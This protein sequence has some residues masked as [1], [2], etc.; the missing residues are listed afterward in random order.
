[1]WDEG[2][3]V[4]RGG[5]LGGDRDGV[6]VLCSFALCVCERVCMFVCLYVYAK[7]DQSL[8]LSLSLS[9][10]LSLSFSLLL[11]FSFSQT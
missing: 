10:P 7:Q 9:L 5:G 1:M 4:I 6:H 3:S 2:R 8:S 11:S